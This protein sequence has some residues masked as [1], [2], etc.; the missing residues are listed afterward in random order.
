VYPL[1]PKPPGYPE[2]VPTDP[3][4]PAK[5]NPASDDPTAK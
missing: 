3:A 1:P 4:A 5:N 2:P